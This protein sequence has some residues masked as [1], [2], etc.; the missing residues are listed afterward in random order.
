VLGTPPVAVLAALVVPV[1]VLPVVGVLP[2]VDV[3]VAGVMAGVAGATEAPLVPVPAGVPAEWLV[4]NCV[5]A[6][7]SAVN[8]VLPPCTPPE[9]ESPSLSVF[10]VRPRV[11]P[12]KDDRL[13]AGLVPDN[14]FVVMI[15]TL[16]EISR[17]R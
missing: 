1:D 5:N 12:N 2:V 17:M 15:L 11:A 6:A 3:V 9:S 16:F 8:R 4:T 14:A 7:S 10:L 13:A